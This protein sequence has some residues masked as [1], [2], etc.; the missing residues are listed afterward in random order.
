LRK[1][2]A[3]ESMQQF[4]CDLKEEAVAVVVEEEEEDEE[5]GGRERIY[6]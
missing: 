6:Y 4:F 3:G 2:L 1:T 5:E